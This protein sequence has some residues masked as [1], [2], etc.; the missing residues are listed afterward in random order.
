MQAAVR[1]IA[2]GELTV[3]EASIQFDVPI[4]TLYLNMRRQGVKARGRLG[5]TGQ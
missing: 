3:A 1:R 4:P 5:M 2:D